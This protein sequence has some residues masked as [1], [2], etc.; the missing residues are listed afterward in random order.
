MIHWPRI[1][2]LIIVISALLFIVNYA[3]SQPVITDSTLFYPQAQYAPEIDGVLDS[4]WYN[5]PRYPVVGNA[6]TEPDDWYDLSMDFRAMWDGINLYYFCDVRDDILYA[7]TDWQYDSVELYNDADYS[8]GQAY[9]GLDDVQLRMHYDDEERSVTVWTNSM[10]PE[11]ETSGMIWEQRETD[12]G[13]TCEISLDLV[14]L[15]MDPV[16]GTL[17]GADVQYNDDDEGTARNHKLISFGTNEQSWNNPSFFG[18]AVLSPWVASDT[19]MVMRTHT[20]PA[21]DGE[22]DDVWLETPYIS[23]TGYIDMTNVDDYYDV[24]MTTRTMWDGNYLY[25]FVTVW[26][27]DLSRDGN[28]DWEDDGIEIYSDGDYSHGAAYDKVNDFQ[29]AFRYEDTAELIQTVHLTGNSDGTAVDLSGVKQAAKKIDDGGIALEVALPMSMLQ[30]NPTSGSVYGME[31]DYNDDDNGGTRDTKLKTYSKSDDTWQYPNLMMPAKL[32]AEPAVAID[33]RTDSRPLSPYRLAQNYPNPFNP[34][35]TIDFSLQKASKV[36][37][38]VYD[39]LGHEVAVLVDENRTPGEYS[40][41]FDGSGLSSGIYF[42]KLE[43]NRTVLT[44]K[45]MLVR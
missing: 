26:D 10:G 27:D 41:R 17:I 1:F 8:D 23:A 16:P 42:Y 12:Y 44:N 20:A 39:L 24:S 32:V 5:A 19:L 3:R 35:T 6:S 37:L 28:G 15:F 36:R 21:I 2:L 43:T 18:E 33:R 29:F 45:M 9:D 22:L 40:V 25:Y 31:V 4:I 30:I 13:W 14:D 7:G 34:V 38:V 11:F